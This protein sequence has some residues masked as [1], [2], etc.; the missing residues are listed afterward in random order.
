MSAGEK[1]I[2]LGLVIK[3]SLRLAKSDTF[4][5]FDTPVGRLDTKNRSIFTDQVILK[6][7]DQVMIFA[8]DSDYTMSDYKNLNGKF[9]QELRL[10]R[11]ENDE[12]VAIKGSIY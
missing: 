10:S 9:T 12:I 6:I 5:L 4:F 1:Q 7:A 8:T 2:L 11:N 3:E